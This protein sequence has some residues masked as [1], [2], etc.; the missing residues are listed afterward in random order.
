MFFPLSI[1]WLLLSPIKIIVD[2]G[3]RDVF[4]ENSKIGFGW[5]LEEVVLRKDNSK[6]FAVIPKVWL[7]KVR[8]LGLKATECSVKIFNSLWIP[9]KL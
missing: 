6:K 9:V 2:G 7:S 8:M 4:I 1:I 5:I 3:Y